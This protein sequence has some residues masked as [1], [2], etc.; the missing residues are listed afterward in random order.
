MSLY[1]V[2]YPNYEDT[3]LLIMGEKDYTLLP[4]LE[5]YDHNLKYLSKDLV[6]KLDKEDILLEKNSLTNILGHYEWM[7]EYND[8]EIYFDDDA[9]LKE[10]GILR[11]RYEE[12]KRLK[13]V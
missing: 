8:A 7:F 3:E 13:G 11:E 9:D 10:V 5:K 2:R 12:L 4:L 6:V 1:V